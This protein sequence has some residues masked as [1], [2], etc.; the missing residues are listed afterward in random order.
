MANLQQTLNRVR[1][2]IRKVVGDVADKDTFFTFDRDSKNIVTN[3]KIDGYHYI[4]NLDGD[5]IKKHRD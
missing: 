4:F 3:Q 5:L 1:S 2:K